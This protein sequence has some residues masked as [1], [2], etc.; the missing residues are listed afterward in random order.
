MCQCSLGYTGRLCEEDIDECMSNPCMNNGEC[1]DLVGGFQ[2]NCSNTGYE[3]VHCETDIDECA[4]QIEYCGHLGQ[5][6]NQP[7][8]FKCICPKSFC[9]VY[10]HTQDPCRLYQPCQNDGNCVENCRDESDY[11]CNCTDGFTG[12]NC[13]DVVS[14]IQNL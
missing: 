14:F 5:C 10:C 13:T 11:Y 3:G 12:K 2:C 6:I 4:M 7:G 9:G 8:T 1:I